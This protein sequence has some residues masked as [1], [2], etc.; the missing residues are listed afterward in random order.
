[1]SHQLTKTHHSTKSLSESSL[2]INQHLTEHLIKTTLSFDDMYKSKL[3]E[4]SKDQDAKSPRKGLLV[5]IDGVL[6]KLS[7]NLSEKDSIFSERSSESSQFSWTLSKSME[8]EE[9]D[10]VR[11]SLTD[12]LDKISPRNYSGESSESSSERSSVSVVERS[13]LKSPDRNSECSRSSWTLSPDMPTRR[14][15]RPEQDS[16]TILIEKASQSPITSPT[17]DRHED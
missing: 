15:V 10:T 13:G 7:D 5:P 4:L 3:L 9:K 11:D 16:F 1:M 2:E 12:L 17:A 8:S 14:L 6:D